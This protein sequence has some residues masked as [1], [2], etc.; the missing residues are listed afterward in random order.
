MLRRGEVEEDDDEDDE[1]D[2][3]DDDD[4]DDD[5][6]EMM[7]TTMMMMMTMKNP[8]V[9][10]GLKPIFPHRHCHISWC[11]PDSPLYPYLQYIHIILLLLISPQYPP[12]IPRVFNHFRLTRPSTSYPPVARHRPPEASQRHGP[13]QKPYRFQNHRGAPQQLDGLQIGKSKKNMDDL[14]APQWPRKHP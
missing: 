12:Q 4:G 14:G 13:H 3:D 6:D 10:I 8:L 11:W 1:D 9:Q 7:A 2:D 5:E